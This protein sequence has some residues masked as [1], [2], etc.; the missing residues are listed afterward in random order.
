MKRT[1][2]SICIILLCF[3]SCQKSLKQIISET[4]E[5]TFIIY[6]YDEFGSPAGSGSGFFIDANGSGISNYHVL[7]GAVKAII[8]TADEKEYEI[9]QVLF[10]DKDWDIVKFS[11]KSNGDT[12]KPLKFSKKKIE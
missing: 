7:D 11:I 9:A 4:E 8:K 3:S 2:F 10:S 5:A 6:T 12:F 1:F